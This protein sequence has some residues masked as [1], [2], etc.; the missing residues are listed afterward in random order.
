MR[1]RRESE[2]TA[3]QVGMLTL[4]RGADP[5]L[6]IGEIICGLAMIIV[7]ARALLRR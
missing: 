6:S 7:I 4:P 3:I 2:A 5:L 1:S